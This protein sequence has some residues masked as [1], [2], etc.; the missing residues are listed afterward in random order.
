M[1]A[2]R[3]LWRA[4]RQAPRAA[5]SMGLCG[6]ALILA[7]A[8]PPASPSPDPGRGAVLLHLP[9]ISG[10]QW[11]DDAMTEGL[12]AGGAATEA[13]IHDW[14]GDKAGLTALLNKPLHEAQTAEVAALLRRQHQADPARPIVLT[15][16]SGGSG[17]AVWALERLPEEVQIDTLVLIQPAL[18]PRYDL[19]R[20]LARVKRRAIVLSSRYDTVILGAGTR[21]LG[22][23]DGV[24]SESAGMVGFEMP[25]GADA[26][27][28]LKLVPVPY[29]AEFMRKGNLGDHLGP[30]MTP[31]ARDV[32][33]PLVREP[34]P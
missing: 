16:H 26:R 9:G 27:Q 10:H 6:V 14:P 33:A 30:M 21:L 19:S 20:A 18:S 15:A 11:L 29:R 23:I 12:V 2:A 1:I 22:T 7:S 32:V 13:L 5:L 28:Y 3:C 34:A 8:S 31:F 25:P 4:A 17:I 24:R